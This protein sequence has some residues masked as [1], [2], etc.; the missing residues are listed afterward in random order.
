MDF[1]QKKNIY[2]IGIK[3]VGMSM[4]AQFLKKQGFN[5]FGSDVPES[6][7]SDKTLAQAKINFKS[8]FSLQDFPEKIDLIIFS[9]AFNE[10]NNI[11]MEYFAGQDIVK[12]SYA[13]AL[14]ALLKDY[15]GISVCGSH[16]KTTVTSWLGYVLDQ[17]GLSP[18][19]L[20]GSYVK[21]LDGSSLSGN[22]KYLILESDEYQNKLKY[23]SPQAVVL[24]NI[25]FDHPDYFKSPADYL[26]VFSDFISKLDESGFLINN[27]EDRNSSKILNKSSA[28][29]ISY[30]IDQ[31]FFNDEVKY[32]KVYQA[33]NCQV[34]KEG[35]SFDLFK[36]DK[37]IASF[38][39]YFPGRHN[40]LN[41]L[42]VISTALELGLSPEEIKHP[43]ES[44]RGASRRF[45]ILGEYKGALIID[46]YAHHPE[47]I[48]ASLQA[49]KE[50]YPDRR[51]VCLFH[52]HTF[53]RTKAF[54]D[55]FAQSFSLC[56]ALYLIEI[57]ASAREE[58]TN[59]SSLDLIDKI[60]Q[61]NKEK[62][63]SQELGYFKDLNQAEKE[64]AAKL[65]SG[66]LLLLL[67]AGDVFR[68]AYNW[69][70]IKI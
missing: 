14:G 15:F 68:L 12:L 66:D 20:I 60:R 40:I 23:L 48:K 29:I 38:N 33:R 19:V 62:G 41:A 9:S 25:S 22:S 13:Q 55:D 58:K 63:L 10:A 31:A 65:R 51:L 50:R 36:D 53:S 2:M 39:I 1:S 34:E 45:D 54:L 43:L 44:F 18:N 49:I 37:F 11:E 17:A 3:G 21:Q 24:N 28:R 59:L 4:L 27:L 57:Y 26:K 46:D 42:A 8:G 56:Q 5:V 30:Y 64:L 52:P 7:P 70:N 61:Y 69:L 6:F 47:E 35:Q 32:E 67:G 16:G